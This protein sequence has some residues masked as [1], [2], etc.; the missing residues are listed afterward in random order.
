M[1]I[2]TAPPVARAAL[3]P[4]KART[5]A[6]PD[7]AY[8]K[9]RP[10]GSIGRLFAS[11]RLAVVPKDVVPPR[12]PRAGGEFEKFGWARRGLRDAVKGSQAVRRLPRRAH[13]SVVK[14]PSAR[15]SYEVR[16]PA[17]P[18]RRTSAFDV[19]FHAWRMRK[20]GGHRATRH[21]LARDRDLSEQSGTTRRA[22][23]GA[24]AARSR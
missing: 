1:P 17:G 4:P 20:F 5:P 21:V 24:I 6:R 18:D 7:G 19:R 14:E 9:R 3:R 8:L 12:D 10:L 11:P 15:D 2:V 23:S 13:A 22:R 16:R